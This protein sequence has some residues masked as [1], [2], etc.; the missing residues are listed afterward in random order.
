MAKLT[1]RKYANGETVIANA[2]YEPLWSHRHTVD[3]RIVFHIVPLNAALEN[4]ETMEAYGLKES[5]FGIAH[6][7]EA[8][9][10]IEKQVKSGIDAFNEGIVVPE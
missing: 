2:D 4:E 9:K 1:L 3:G 7:T 5:S 10:Y 6:A 8:K